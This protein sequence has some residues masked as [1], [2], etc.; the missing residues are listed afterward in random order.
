M[1]DNT[2]VSPSQLKKNR[3][4]LLGILASFVLP[5][6]AGD[7]A[8]KLGWYQG[9]KTNHGQLIDPPV[10]FA[11]FAATRPDKGLVGADFVRANW[12]LLYVVPTQCEQSCENRLYQMRQVRKALG[13]ESERVRPLLVMTSPASSELQALLAREFADFELLY[14]DASAIN[15]ALASVLPE[16]VNKGQLFIIDPMGW[17]ML[18]YA[19]EE[20]EKNSVIK[21]EDILHDVKKLLKASRIG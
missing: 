9:G 4:L 1:T 15:T 20:N 11:D 7:L 16:A 2:V 19:P 6:V 17:I 21:A 13:K 14:A 18:T 10:A 5:F 3:W 12:W 8:Y